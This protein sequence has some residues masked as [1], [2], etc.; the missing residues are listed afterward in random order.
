MGRAKFWID[1][2]RP[3]E[4]GIESTDKSLT[5]DG[6]YVALLPHKDCEEGARVGR[7]L[8]D[9]LNEL[10]RLRAENRRLRKAVRL[11]EP[12]I[13]CMCVYHNCTCCVECKA[14]YEACDTALRRAPC[15]RT[16]EASR[17]ARRESRRKTRWP[18]A[19]RL[20]TTTGAS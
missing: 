9:A 13:G 18:R 3:G 6:H 20:R 10:P 16:R 15:G 2:I 4:W 17:D 11:A 12:Q 8:V 5:F 19:A 14:A 7:G 1:M